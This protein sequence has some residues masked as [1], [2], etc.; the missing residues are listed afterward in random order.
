MAKTINKDFTKGSIPSVVLGMALP[1]MAAQ[2]VNVLYN[3]VDRIYIGHIPGTG[4]LALTGVGLT[5]PVISVISAFT[6][7]FGQG[8]APLCSIAR[9]KGDREEASRVMGNAFS[10][11]LM[12]SVVLMVIGWVVMRPVLMFLGG[13]ENTI[14]YGCD[15]LRI[16]LLGTPFVFCS[17]GMNAYINA[18]GFPG[19]GMLTVLLGAAANTI[20]D[21]IFIFGFGMGVEGAAWATVLSQLLSAVWCL[22]FLF[23]SKTP[24]ELSHRTMKLGK[25]RVGRMLSLGI[26]NFIAGVTNSLVQAVANYQ[27]GLFGGDLYVGTMTMIDSLRTVFLEMMRGFGAGLQPV[28]GYNYGAGRK[29]RVLEC[30]RFSVVGAGIFSAAI[31]LIFELFPGTLIR[32]MT[33]DPTLIAVA[34]PAVRVYYCGIIFMSLQFIAQNTFQGLGRA[35]FAICFSLLRKA[36]IVVPLMLILPHLWGLGVDGVFW[37]EPI[38]DLVGGVA[39][40]TTMYLTVYRPIS[41]E[42]KET[43]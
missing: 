36:A 3:I 10:M 18:Q 37:A 42:L 14:D 22:S 23:G 33:P 11:L 25:Q 29:D 30:V 40:V 9:G 4:S 31:W 6:G 32:L 12:A 24:L 8:G 19:R 7:L 39:S 5:L 26:S 17:L 1:L 16:Y 13:S 15:Y 28:I 38:S 41:R 21:P 27:L 34:I 35:K 43:V 2:M 20:L